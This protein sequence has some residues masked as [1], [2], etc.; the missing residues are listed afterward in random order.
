MTSPNYLKAIFTVSLAV[1]LGALFLA[2]GL[3]QIPPVWNSGTINRIALVVVLFC[4]GVWLIGWVVFDAFETEQL[5]NEFGR[6]ITDLQRLGGYALAIIIAGAFAAMV[7]SLGSIPVFVTLLATVVL[8][9]SIGDYVVI[10]GLGELVQADPGVKSPLSAYYT[11]RPHML[12][13]C[14]QLF[15]VALAAAAYLFI[16]RTREPGSEWIA[17]L[18]LSLSVLTN[19]GILWTW[20]ISRVKR[21]YRARSR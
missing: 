17:Y 2:L 15:L 5:D 13:H 18:I 14:V 10:K 7:M 1:L 8:A 9:T 3:H 20:R 21:D 12:L 6:S 4:L 16:I 19:E 11:E